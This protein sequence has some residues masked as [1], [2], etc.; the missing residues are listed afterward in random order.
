MH[1]LGKG[2]VMAFGYRVLI[3]VLCSSELWV[4]AP[5]LD[6]FFFFQFE[7]SGRFFT[8]M[9]SSQESSCWVFRVEGKFGSGMKRKPR[10]TRFIN[11]HKWSLEGARRVST[12]VS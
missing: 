9:P 5:S 11:S 1:A 10:G 6:N 2:L 3:C 4:D 12:L 7:S 8:E